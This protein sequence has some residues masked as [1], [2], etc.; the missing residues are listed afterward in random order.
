ME[1]RPS[2]ELVGEYVPEWFI[3]ET[4]DKEVDTGIESD[5]EVT[6]TE[7]NEEPKRVPIASVGHRRFVAIQVEEIFDVKDDPESMTDEEQDDYGKEDNG[8]SGLLSLLLS[9]VA[10]SLT[11]AV[12]HPSPSLQEWVDPEVEVSHGDE[13]YA[14]SDQEPSHIWVPENI[15][16]MHP[17]RRGPQVQLCDVDLANDL[18]VF[19]DHVLNQGLIVDVSFE[20]LWDVE[21]DGEEGHRSNVGKYP[22]PGVGWGHNGV[23]VLYRPPDSL[24]PLQR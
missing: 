16:I 6:D 2:F 24:V 13:G 18:V 19:A 7:A 9:H 17:E 10:G 22:P 11:G 15:L 1:T 23:P 8:L 3:H 14:T 4:I 21:E 12:V 5:E 20:E